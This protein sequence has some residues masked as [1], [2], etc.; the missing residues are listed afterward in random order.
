MRG[1]VIFVRVCNFVRFYI[2]D[3]VEWDRWGRLGWIR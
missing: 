1:F 3:E 2:L